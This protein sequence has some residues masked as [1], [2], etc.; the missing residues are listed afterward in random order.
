MAALT[1]ALVVEFT[2][3]LAAWFIAL[4]GTTGNAYGT[5][6]TGSSYGAWKKA[7]DAEALVMAT[8]DY[9]IVAPLGA[10]FRAMKTASDGLR[11]GTSLSA[12]AFQSLAM[13]CSSAGSAEG[14]AS[15]V[16][17]DSFASYYNLTATTKWQCLFAPDLYDVLQGALGRPPSAHNTYFEVLQS[18]AAS[19]LGRLIVGT[20]FSGP[21]SIDSA[22]YAGGFGQ[23]KG[24]AVEGS[25]TVTVTGSWRK[26]DG[27]AATGD[28]TA[29][30]GA[31]NSTVTLTPAFTG[32]LLLGVTNIVAGVG[33]TAGTL[34]AEAARP[35]GRDNPPT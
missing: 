34:Y 2:D 21:A 12:P 1:P 30:V 17:L 4:K 29:T 22:K 11:V 32:A 24:L 16:D 3:K 33:I 20:G 23:V 31:G 28:G 6:V 26:T 7:D 35:S 5:G 27:T 19:A 13:A 9:D 15:V 25:A 18:G 14:L 8:E 10:G